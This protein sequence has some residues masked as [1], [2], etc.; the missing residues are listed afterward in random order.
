MLAKQAAGH[1]A[2]F[3]DRAIHLIALADFVVSRRS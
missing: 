1:L 2:G 3:G